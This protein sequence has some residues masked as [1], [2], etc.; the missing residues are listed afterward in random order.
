[1]VNNFAIIDED[2][3]LTCNAKGNPKPNYQIVFNGTIL[4]D[5]ED[6]IVV[7]KNVNCDNNGTYVCVANNTWGELQASLNV[8][9]GKKPSTSTPTITPNTTTTATGTGKGNVHVLCTV[10][11]KIICLTHDQSPLKFVLN[12]I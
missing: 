10:L 5:S 3:T 8:I 2:I 1:M 11:W 9:T 6:G 4:E 12:H 7:I